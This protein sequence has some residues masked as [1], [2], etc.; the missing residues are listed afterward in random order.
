MT[1][2]LMAGVLLIAAAAALP[3]YAA[4][5]DGAFLANAIK[6][7]N[8][9]IALGKLAEHN[10]AD[11][12]VRNFGQMLVADHT[13]AKHDAVTVAKQLKV[14]IPTTMTAQAQS[15]ERKLKRLSGKAF[16]TAFVT[17][18]IRDHKTAISTF[19]REESRA[20]HPRVAELAK[21]TLPTLRKHLSV[22]QQLAGQTK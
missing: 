21:N 5:S 20:T 3:A 14:Q 8:S 12:A 10:G 2:I 6:S 15:E 7:D 19:K 11:R 1:R 13:R 17:D 4:P 9:E 16:D 22:A 18:M